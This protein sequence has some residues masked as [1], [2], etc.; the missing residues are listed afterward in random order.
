MESLSF[1]RAS[2]YYDRTRSMSAA[3]TDAVAELLMA[4]LEGRGS[5]L[6]IGIG[7][8]R[9]ALPLVARGASIH[10]ID[11]SHNML[12]VLRRKSTDIPVAIADATRLPFPDHSFGAALGC[13][14]LHLIPNWRDAAAELTRVVRPGG[15]ILIDLGGW[16]GG[17][18]GRVERRFVAETGIANARPGASAPKEVDEVMASMRVP[19]RLLRPI[20]E[21][22]TY[23]YGELVDR[24]EDGIYSYTWAVEPD[25][26][27][28]IAR[29]LRP[30]IEAE[31]GALDAEREHEWTVQ[32]RAYDLP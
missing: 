23:T 6:E 2:E 9:I 5:V 32:W 19:V 3:T 21:T 12:D 24:I 25:R 16:G 11:L 27:V 26:R 4:E 13:H 1:D 7:T 29:A 14:V 15:V 31:L 28:R 20:A 17:D 18:W 22:H 30:W 10:G 8:G